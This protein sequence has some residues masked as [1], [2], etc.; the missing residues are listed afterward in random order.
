MSVKEMYAVRAS[1]ELHGLL[2]LKVV[3]RQKTAAKSNA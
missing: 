2:L 3:A 1:S